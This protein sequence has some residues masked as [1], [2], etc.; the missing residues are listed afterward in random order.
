MFNYPIVSNTM[1]NVTISIKSE[2]LVLLTDCR[3]YILEEEY[4]III[5]SILKD[6]QVSRKPK[7]G[8]FD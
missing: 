1:M 7:S 4:L 8:A 2:L 6:N 5:I 3:L